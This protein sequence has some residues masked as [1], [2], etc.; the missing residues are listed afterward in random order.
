MK[1][2]IMG[3]GTSTGVPVIGCKCKVCQSADPR[4]HRYR[5]SAML[6]TDGG[7][8][9]LIDCSPDFREQMLQN[10]FD[11][12]DAIL[13][14]HEHYDHVGGLDDVRP[15]SF[16]NEMNVY[17]QHN[18]A[19]NLKSRIPY[20]F[21]DKDKRYPGVPLLNLCD[22]EPHKPFDV[23]DVS[24]MPFTVMHGKMPILGFRINDLA[25][26][27]DMKTIADEDLQYVL[28]AKTLVVNVL[29]MQRE[30]HS[31]QLL[32]EALAFVEKVK[33]EKAVFI[34][35]THEVGLHANVNDGLPANCEFAYDGMT[36][37][38]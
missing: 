8:H 5:M 26:I 18:F 25:F 36:I 28:G 9:I 24:V 23:A 11:K 2:T 33:P 15:F 1:L 32:P 19:V 12:L 13:I 4:D 16:A 29:R 6:Q 35:M 34:H 7:A 27:T 37:E 3:S 21:V 20:C 14:T 30:H 10:H 38:C 22:V 17:T 31:H